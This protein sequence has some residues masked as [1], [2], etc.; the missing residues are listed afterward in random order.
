VVDNQLVVGSQ[1][2]ADKQFL[3]EDI[4]MLVDIQ[5]PEMVDNWVLEDSHLRWMDTPLVKWLMN[6]PVAGYN[7]RPGHK[8]HVSKQHPDVGLSSS[9]CKVSLETG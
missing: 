9:P 1:S 3:V 2:F 5:I 7:G 6:R 4:R 8:G